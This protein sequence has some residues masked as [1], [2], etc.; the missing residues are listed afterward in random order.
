MLVLSK[1][2][3]IKDSYEKQGKTYSEIINETG[4]NY[5]TVYKYANKTDF[6]ENLKCNSGRPRKIDEFIPL[7]DLWL[8]ADEDMPRKQRHTA[9]KVY[10]RLKN[11][12][13]EFNLSYRT[14]CGYVSKKKKTIKESKC[15]VDLEHR[16]GEAQ[17]DF[18]Q[19]EFIE[20]GK[21]FT[22]HYLV[23]TF[24]ADNAYLVQLFKGENQECLLSGLQ[25]FFKRINGVPKKIWFDNLSAAIIRGSKNEQFTRFELHYG[26]EAVF[27]NP[28]SGH[29]KGNVENKVGYHRRNYF[30]PIPQF[31][32]IDQYN[33]ELLDTCEK[34]WDREHYQKQENI[35]SLFKS[36]SHAFLSFPQTEFTVCKN[37]FAKC[38]KYGRVVTDKKTYS[39]SPEHAESEVRLAITH[40]KVRIYGA[41]NELI[42][43]HNRL[44]GEENESLN[45]L[46]FLNL[47]SHRPR[48]LRYSG[49]FDSLPTNWQEK[50]NKS[51]TTVQKDIIQLLREILL[52][53]SLEFAEL[54]MSE[55]VKSGVDDVDSLRATFLRLLNPNPFPEPLKM[56]KTCLALPKISTTVND[57]GEL[58]RRAVE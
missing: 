45:W 52:C 12:A 27:C 8:K 47:I 22:G 43:T 16:A 25:T 26:F 33:T 1:Q 35:S 15:Y 56:D 44:Y 7:I 19:A 20:N 50:I 38:N 5:R 18:G 11:E 53:K 39:V 28:A 32:N 31:S 14:V 13:V 51:D 3:I 29:E 55:T 24:P 54:V 2:K 10:N 58:F 41:N 17:A 23:L 9:Q 36:N 40:D 37:V 57:Y 6:S 49:F 48:S 21:R 4:Y 34:D 42:D 30:V 46:P